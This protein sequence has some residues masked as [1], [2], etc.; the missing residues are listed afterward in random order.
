MPVMSDRLLCAVA[1]LLCATVLGPVSEAR[2]QSLSMRQ[3]L[4]FSAE[5]LFGFYLDDRSL[6]RGGRD[7]TSHHTVIGVGWQNSPSLLAIPRLGID[8]F[9]SDAFSLGGNLGFASRTD[10]GH[11]TVSLLLA[12]RVGYALR[13]GHSVCFWPR[14]GLSYAASDVE[15]DPYDSHVLALTLDAPFSLALTDGFAFLIGPVL[16]LGFLAKTVGRHANEIMFGLMVGLVGWT[17]L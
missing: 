9:V 11:T 16:E 8:Y 17:G 10:D 12:A 3:N 13:L 5:R 6:D 15:G 2:A 14:G 4:V 7:D 1:V